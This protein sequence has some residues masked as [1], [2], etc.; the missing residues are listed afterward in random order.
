MDGRARGARDAVTVRLSRITVLEADLRAAQARLARA[1]ADLESAAIRAPTEG[2]IV[3]RIVQPGGAIEAGMPVISMWL[4]DDLWVESWIDEEE[5]SSIHVGSEATVTFHALPRQEFTG[6]VERIGLATDLEIPED[7]V[8][9]PR[10]SRMR[11]APVVSVRIRLDERPPD[12]LPGLSAV[13]AIR[14]EG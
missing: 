9:Q 3:R 2:A 6:T 8:P 5:L 4:G 11:G 10:F 1:E 12:L 13:V 14:K 7:E